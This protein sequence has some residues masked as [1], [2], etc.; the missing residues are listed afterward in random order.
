MKEWHTKQEKRIIE[1]YG[2]THLSKSGYDGK[3]GRKLVEVRSVRKDNRFRIQQDVHRVLV[4]NKGYYIF[5]NKHGRSKKVPAVRVSKLIGVGK[6]FEDRNY[7]H[8]FLKVNQVFKK[9]IVIVKR[10]K[11]K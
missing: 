8:K 10:R 5:V 6:W 11:K 4:R 9:V 3:I 2:G 1:R 7:P